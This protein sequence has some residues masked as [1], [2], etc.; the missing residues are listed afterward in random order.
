VYEGEWVDGAP[1]C[2]EYREP[3]SEEELRFRDPIIA[4]ESF[5]LPPLGLSDPQLILDM[6]KAETRIN[7]AGRRGLEVP[8][9]RES[10]VS[11]PLSK[12]CMNRAAVA[13]ALLDVKGDGLVPLSLLKPFFE[14]LG[15]DFTDDNIDAIRGE[16][17]IEADTALSF[18]EAIDIGTYLLTNAEMDYDYEYER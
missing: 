1:Q 18:P 15:S 4:R 3:T 17:E 12:E 11:V 6:A 14:E 5:D 7:N 9:G 2:G 8:K 16:L 13:F 10:P